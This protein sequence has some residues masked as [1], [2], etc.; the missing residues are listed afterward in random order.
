MGRDDST[1]GGESGCRGLV[2]CAS[3]HGRRALPCAVCVSWG[4]WHCI[5]SF[6][7]FG[8]RRRINESSPPL[9]NEQTREAPTHVTVKPKIDSSSKCSS[10]RS[11]WR[12]EGNFRIDRDTARH[13]CA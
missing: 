9:I 3:R 2:R 6:G 13:S 5:C 11:V 4:G 7:S 8:L 12:R 1:R 10:A